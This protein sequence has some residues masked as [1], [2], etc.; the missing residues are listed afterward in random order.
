MC[1]YSSPAFGDGLDMIAS[2]GASYT[3]ASTR[4][5]SG[6]VLRVDAVETRERLPGRHRNTRGGIQPSKEVVER[7]VLEHHDHQ[8]I[9][10]RPTRTLRN[11]VGLRRL[12]RSQR[13]SAHGTDPDARRGQGGARHSGPARDAASLI[14]HVT[15]SQEH[16]PQRPSGDE[17]RETCM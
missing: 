17:R 10:P 11:L 14:I 8:M 16:R 13:S 7:P 12:P 4:V 5:P 9:E 6:A 15:S 3:C 1:G 2:V